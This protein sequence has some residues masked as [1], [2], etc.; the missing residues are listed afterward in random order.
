MKKVEDKLRG[1]IKKN[2]ATCL[3]TITSLQTHEKK[4][5]IRVDEIWF[6]KYS[7]MKERD[8]KLTMSKRRITL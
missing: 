4:H 1:L 5:A 7:K 6:F 8:V 3:H 2:L